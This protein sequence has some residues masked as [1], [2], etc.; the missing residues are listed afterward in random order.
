MV[1]VAGLEPA[2]IF[3]PTDFKSVASAN[4]ATRAA[5]FVVCPVMISPK[6]RSVK[7][8]TSKKP[9]KCNVT[10]SKYGMI[11]LDQVSDEPSV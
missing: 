7:Y 6:K 2:W 8:D 10:I 5:F 1:L 3:G 9:S 4:S 11:S